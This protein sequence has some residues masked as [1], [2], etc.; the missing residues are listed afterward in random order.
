MITYRIAAGLHDDQ[1]QLLMSSYG[2]SINKNTLILE[3]LSRTDLHQHFNAIAAILKGNP[4]LD[5]RWVNI[6]QH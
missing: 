2:R 6:S 3:G 5:C 1:A 4:I